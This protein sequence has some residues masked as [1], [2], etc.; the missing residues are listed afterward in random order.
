MKL[1]QKS[2]LIVG[3]I[4]FLALV[5]LPAC[6]SSPAIISTESEPETVNET[7]T[8][9]AGKRILWVDS[10]HAEY[11]W[12]ASIEAGLREALQDSGVELEIVRMDTKRNTSEEFGIQAAVDAK[13]IIDAYNPDVIIACDD[14]AQKYLVV[15]YL[16]GADTPVIFCGV[17]WDA[18]A[19]NY[20]TGSNV[21]GMVEVE[22]PEQVVEL[23]KPY[24]AGDRIAYLTVES[25][26]ENKVVDIYNDRFFGGEMKLYAVTSLEEF[27]AAFL[28]AQD[29]VDIL[30]IG[31]NAGIDEWDEA[32]MEAF[33]QENTQIPSGTINS[34]MAPYV[35]ITLAKSAEEQ[36]EW[37]AQTAL[38]ILDGASV[39]SIPITTNKKGEL[40]LNFNL[41]DQLDVVFTPSMLRNAEI[42]GGQETNQ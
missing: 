28:Q 26:T 23:L 39:S 20:E 41:V 13:E 3:L 8:T 2:R 11:E 10:Y 24:A 25:A 19:Y 31:N 27:K 40:I 5:A 36:G 37:S 14:N 30:F 17:N 4:I 15:P 21:T 34:W 6:T 32:E 18:S 16:Y 12:S 33:I 38:Q 22:L 29:E 9:Y 42:Y 7:Q 1:I 35:L